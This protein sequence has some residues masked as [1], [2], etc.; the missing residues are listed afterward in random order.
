MDSGD[1][2]QVLGFAGILPTK[3]SPG[4]KEFLYFEKNSK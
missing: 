4:H 3:L 2:T 1:E